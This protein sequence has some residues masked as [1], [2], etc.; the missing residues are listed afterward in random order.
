VQEPVAALSED[1]TSSSSGS[2]S[3]GDSA[4]PVQ[5]AQGRKRARK[6]TPLA[7]Q[8]PD[9]FLVIASD[10]PY[11]HQRDSQKA[12]WTKALKCMHK[13]NLAVE[14]TKYRQ[15]KAWCDKICETHHK[16]CMK[17]L[18]KS[19][20]ADVPTPTVLDT[21]ACDWVDYNLRTGKASKI[22]KKHAE[23][24]RL[25][26]VS[27]SRTV[28]QFAAQIASARE[29]HNAIV[30][31]ATA[32][33]PRSSPSP[34]MSPTS[35]TSTAQRPTRVDIQHA[36]QAIMS[37]TGVAVSTADAAATAEFTK[38]LVEREQQLYP[39]N[40]VSR[41]EQ[42]VP[43]IMQTL[44]VLCIADFAELDEGQEA[45]CT[46]L[47]VLVMNRFQKVLNSFRRENGE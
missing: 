28:P 9:I 33:Q 35:T 38:A 31:T 32:S 20:E 30:R 40:F 6:F 1:G 18:N 22:N 25:S 39:S 42:Y 5:L 4:T 37:P 23:I 7:Q 34:L 24:I 8:I 10:C 21:V 3:D 43:A 12:C 16:E 2:T 29:K 47:P 26:C 46:T 13:K 44:G 45:A 15:L 19:G 17:N 27:T 36:L 11:T 41:L 14:C